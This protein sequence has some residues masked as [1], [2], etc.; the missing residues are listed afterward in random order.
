MYSTL[1][2]ALYKFQHTC[3]NTA[4]SQDHTVL[5]CQGSA[6]VAHFLYHTHFYTL[7]DTGSSRDS[8]NTTLGLVT[9]GTGPLLVHN[10]LNRCCCTHHTLYGTPLVMWFLWEILSSHARYHATHF[11]LLLWVRCSFQWLYLA[12]WVQYPDV[13]PLGA[14]F[15]PYQVQYHMRYTAIAELQNCWQILLYQMRYNSFG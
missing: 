8:C 15:V 7:D 6:P 9:Q 12:I 5:Y 13:V 14:S 3:W 10:T 1:S 11:T 2:S 4:P